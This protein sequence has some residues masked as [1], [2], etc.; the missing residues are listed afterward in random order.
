MS[1]NE[2]LSDLFADI[3]AVI[4]DDFKFK[5][6]LAIGD[7]HFKY[8]SNAKNL[9]DFG[10]SLLGGIAIG[11]VTSAAWYTGLG[12]GGKALLTVGLIS[13]PIG[14]VV[15]AAALG[16]AG[17]FGF[18]KIKDNYIKK[19]EDELVTKVP[20]FL[21]TPLDL[22]GLSIATLMLPVSVKMAHA[23]G[24]FCHIER[25]QILKY[26]VDEWGYN[27]EFIEK[28]IQAQETKMA[29]FSY[30]NYAKTLKSVCGKT[31]EFK[32]DQMTEEILDFQRQIIL[33]D[34][35]IHSDEEKELATL[36]LYLE[37]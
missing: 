11:G 5:K 33:M 37:T 2:E 30:K 34:G 23:D 25:S 1:I 36:K 10:E 13:Q 29:G 12:F 22:L 20:K 4:D 28:L 16:A 21:N 26:F 9:A 14:W 24:H 8:M 15:G 6:K 3:Q 27:P 7:E 32:T 18:K 35:E 31:S 17:I 19:A